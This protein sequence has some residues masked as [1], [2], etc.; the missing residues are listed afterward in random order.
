LNFLQPFID[1]TRLYI[2]FIMVYGKMV[3]YFITQPFYF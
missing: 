2:G 3:E 1:F